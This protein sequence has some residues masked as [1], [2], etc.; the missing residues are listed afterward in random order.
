MVRA[1]KY[2]LFNMRVKNC[3]SEYKEVTNKQNTG[4]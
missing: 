2:T 3:A 4:T 1:Y